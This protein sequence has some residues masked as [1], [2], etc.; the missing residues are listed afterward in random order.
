MPDMTASIPHQLGREEAKRRIQD[1][2]A[3]V[4]QR[5]GSLFTNL[6]ETWTD[7][8]LHFSL[9]A[10]GQSVSGH[11]TVEDR[12]VNV[13]VALPWFLSMLASTVKHRI[14]TEGR[15]MFGLLGHE[16]SEGGKKDK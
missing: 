14:E 10:V 1:Q 16:S 5:H 11:L 9:A 15:D 4:R 6:Q 3:I 7:D 13:T 2:I 12:V 8:T